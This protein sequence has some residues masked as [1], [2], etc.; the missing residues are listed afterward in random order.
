MNCQVSKFLC[1]RYMG[2]KWLVFIGPLYLIGM[3]FDDDQRANII[4]THMLREIGQH[5]QILI[6]TLHLIANTIERNYVS[7]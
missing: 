4:K 7:S 6:T 1:L 5:L 3:W 2:L